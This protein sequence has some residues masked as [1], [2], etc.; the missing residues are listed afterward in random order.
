MKFNSQERNIFV[1]SDPHY[2]HKNL[3]KH[4]TNWKDSYKITTEN[5]TRHYNA[6]SNMKCSKIKEDGDIITAYMESSLFNEAE[7]KRILKE[8][9]S[10]F[11]PSGAHR[12]FKTLDAHNDMLVNN[13]NKTVGQDDVLFI[14]GDIAFGG[15]EN[16]KIFMDR[17]ICKE[18]HLIY[19][20]HD[21]HIINNKNN[22]RDCFTTTSFYR[23]VMIDKEMFVFF[24][25]PISEWNG[26]HKSSFHLYGHQHNLPNK[27]FSNVGR[28]MDCGFD[29]HPEFR[30]YN[31][32]TEIIPLLKDR[33][34]IEHHPN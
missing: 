27:R 14:L 17:I 3:I 18:I 26:G 31:I 20:N 9:K 21:D 2:S 1:C 22:I 12:N 24:H 29:G 30:P 19:G 4:L 10:E 11:T 16:V 15:Y 28:S 32:I 34:I 23:E 33:P 13:I 25:Y 7:A 5:S 8:F 6:L